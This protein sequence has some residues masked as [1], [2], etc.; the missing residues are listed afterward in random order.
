MTCDLKLLNGSLISVP[1]G[2]SRYT[3]ILQT[4]YLFKSN[5]H[6]KSHHVCAFVVFFFFLHCFRYNNYNKPVVFVQYVGI[7][8]V[9][10][11]LDS[12]LCTH[13][14]YFGVF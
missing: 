14:E 6:L 10:S 12:V 8:W 4:C 9:I 7:V 3:F 1:S 11:Y 5:D 13:Y 2:V